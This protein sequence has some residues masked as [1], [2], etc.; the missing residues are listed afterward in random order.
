MTTNALKDKV[1]LITGATSGIGLE[2]AIALANMGATVV[3]GGRDLERASNAVIKIRTASN[4][5]NVDFLL[6]D[7]SDFVEVKRFAEEFKQQYKRLDVLVNNAGAIF[8]EYD[9]NPQGV[10]MTMALNLFSI[11]LLTGSLL[12]VLQHSAPSRIINVSSMVHKL[13]KNEFDGFND[14]SSY[15]ALNSYALSKLGLLHFNTI[16]SEKLQGTGIT[17]N[18]MHPGWVKSNFGSGFYTGFYGFLDTIFKPVQISSQKG[19]ETI[20]YLASS[21]VVEKISGKYFV[22][23]KVIPS[24]SASY[25]TKASDYVWELCRQ[26]TGFEYEFKE[27]PVDLEKK[28]EDSNDAKAKKSDDDKPGDI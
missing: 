8:K 7:L 16:L 10:E 12:D 2:T 9:E 11:Y 24:S 23:N 26:Q 15:K 6:A 20:V 3:V 27:K 25:N 5:P 18:A 4:N 14:E 21:P 22:K 17:S 1:C 28:V 19:A 13:G